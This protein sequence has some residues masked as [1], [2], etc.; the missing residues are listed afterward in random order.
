MSTSHSNGGDPLA[1]LNLPAAIRVQGSKLLCAI[2]SAATLLDA[3]RAADRAEGFVLGIETLRALN[4][5][6]IE[7]LYLVF[8]RA[9]QV[10]QAELSA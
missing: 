5:E 7:G 6:D 9:F 10:R 1:P 4:P 8:D 3:L 2:R